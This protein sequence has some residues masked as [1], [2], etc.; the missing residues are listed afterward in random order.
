MRGIEDVTEIGE[1]MP[2]GIDSGTAFIE[3]AVGGIIP[4]KDD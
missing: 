3:Q 2:G 1:G 4:T